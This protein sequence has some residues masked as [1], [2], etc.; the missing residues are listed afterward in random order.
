M[1]FVLTLCSLD[2]NLVQL[3]LKM[4]I[5]LQPGGLLGILSAQL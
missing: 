4:L 1:E 3:L 5:G 2:G